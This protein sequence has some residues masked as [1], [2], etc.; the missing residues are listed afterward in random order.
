MASHVET[1][2]IRPGKP[3]SKVTFTPKV[4]NVCYDYRE[5]LD[6]IAQFE[7]TSVAEQQI[8]PPSRKYAQLEPMNSAG[9]EKLLQLVCSK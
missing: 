2:C 7:R 5:L 1:R 3:V 9:G 8:A 4:F 6:T